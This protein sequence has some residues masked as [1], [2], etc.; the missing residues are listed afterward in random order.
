MTTRTIFRRRLAAST[1]LCAAA[2][3]ATPAL[4]Q[5]VGGFGTIASRVGGPTTTHNGSTNTLEVAAPDN[6]ILNWTTFNV[7]D[8]H[9]A[10]YRHTSGPNGGK[11]AILNRVVAGGP[12][13]NISGNLNSDPNVAVYVINPNGVLFGSTA[14]VNV[15]SLVASTQGL[16]DADFIDGDDQ[17]NFT[18]ASDS[19][20]SVAG[21]AQINNG[22]RTISFWR[23]AGYCRAGHGSWRSRSYRG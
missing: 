13:T 1:A 14:R 5:A 2:F 6:A 7:P 11:I 3:A 23:L 22:R 15:G 16:T 17:L 20:I 19:A 10:N 4:A 9:T 12:Q 8:G 21:G 18:G